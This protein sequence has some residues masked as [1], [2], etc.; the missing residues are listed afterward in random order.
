VYG[1]GDRLP[2]W[3]PLRLGRFPRADNYALA[4]LGY[5]GPRRAGTGP[6]I[7]FDVPDEEGPPRPKNVVLAPRDARGGLFYLMACGHYSLPGHAICE[8][9]CLTAP[10]YKPPFTYHPEWT[11]WL[12]RAERE[13]RWHAPTR[14]R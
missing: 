8:R 3:H 13:K 6:G 4:T 7:A 9:G 12:R 11:P 5:K 2:E 14:S 1:P 10:T